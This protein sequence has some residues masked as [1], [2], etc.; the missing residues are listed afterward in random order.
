[1]YKN[2]FISHSWSY[3]DHYNGLIRLLR[4]DPYFHF[5]DYS[6]PKDDPIHNANND[7]QLRKAIKDQ[8]SPCSVIL[9][10]AGMYAH[11]SKWINKEIDLAKYGFSPPK[12]IIAVEYW[13]SQRTSTIVKDAADKV[14]RWN[15]ASIINAIKEV[16]R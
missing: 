1:M 14:V 6:V 3:G 11:Y 8:M 10:M 7:A 4:K 9:I 2:I 12:P 15:S 16:V 5:R 13:G